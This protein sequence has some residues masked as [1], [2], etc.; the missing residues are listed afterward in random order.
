MR[1]KAVFYGICHICTELL[2]KTNY[3]RLLRPWLDTGA[4]LM[5]F[6]Q[7]G[8]FRGVCTRVNFLPISKIFYMVTIGIKTNGLSTQRMRKTRFEE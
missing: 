6:D 1:Q 4:S 5:F 7:N 8:H 3:Q 2:Q